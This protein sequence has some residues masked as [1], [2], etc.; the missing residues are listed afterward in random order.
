MGGGLPQMGAMPVVCTPAAPSLLFCKD[1]LDFP[2]RSSSS[3][4]STPTVLMTL[5]LLAQFPGWTCDPGLANQFNDS[6]QLPLNLGV[7]LTNVR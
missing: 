7:S 3:P 6:L 2:L 5:T 1:Y 4:F